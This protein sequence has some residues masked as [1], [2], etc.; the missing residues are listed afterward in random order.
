MAPTTRPENH[1]E[2]HPL[3][4][5]WPFSRQQITLRLVTAEPPAGKDL[6]DLV[7]PFASLDDRGGF[8]R[9]LLAEIA[10]PDGASITRLV[11]KLQSDEYPIVPEAES[12]LWN[13]GTVES[14]W[15]REVGLLERA[16][17]SRSGI[18]GPVE[19]L[20]R[21]P[22][23]AA[24]LPPTIFCKRRRAFFAAPCPACGGPLA[25]FRE[26][27]ALED[28]GL[29]RHDL[30]LVRFL[31]CPACIARG[32]KTLYTLIRESPMAGRDV[33]D[34]GD[35]FRAYRRLATAAP[36][37]NGACLPCQGCA[38]VPTCYPEDERVRGDAPRLL[39]PVTFYESRCIALEPLH[40]RYDEF[41]TLLAGAGFDQVAS[42]VSEP[43]RA[44]LMR[45]IRPYFS[46]RA[47]YLFAQDAGG[48][49]GLEVLRL[50]LTL[51]A[52]LCRAVVNLHRH[53]GAPH[54]A[55]GPARA[56]VL[57]PDQR[58]GLPNLWNFRAMLLGLGNAMPRQLR[59]G[60]PAD[61]PARPY[62][63]PRLIDPVFS[64]PPLRELPLTDQ[65]GVLSLRQLTAAR[66]G[67]TAVLADLACETSEL[68]EL[69]DK[70]AIEVSVVQARPPLSFS[71]IASP[72]GSEGRALRL[73][74]VPA[75]LDLETRGQL[76]QLVNQPLARAR[77]SIYPCLD[78]PCDV[79][80]LGMMLLVSLLG[81]G[82]RSPAQVAKA[83]ADVASQVA[84]HAR[85]HP[86]AGVEEIGEHACAL[87]G[88]GGPDG[89][90]AK[91]QLFHEPER[92]ARAADAI[93]D[94][95][96]LDTLLVGLRAVTTI[97]GF[98]ICRSYSDFDPAHR[99]VN[100]EFLL[101]LVDSLVREVDAS[102][103]GLPGRRREI[104]DAIARVTREAHVTPR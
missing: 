44:L 36:G 10:G 60:D 13:N 69:G 84:V 54:L 38:D 48:K 74:G 82:T 49:L 77:F 19:V 99:E 103:F 93:P 64:A 67:R 28:R 85:E 87:F 30:S 8:S 22:G 86:S 14:A 63:G 65:P 17:G 89:P 15:R 3:D 31:G 91:R 35:L 95:L 94:G 27:R 2:G 88:A 73:R 61:L 21:T 62:V 71:F 81:N 66:D 79:H 59:A 100:A 96:W 102:L 83:V 37:S 4:P 26:S 101:G 29:P 24:H 11:L 1:P 42:A 6:D 104:H 57:V 43:G 20:G 55:I 52:Q 39:S 33:G 78:V 9:T 45:D 97:P 76:E 16:G 53:S 80:G 92:H 51:F 32:E 40:F 56:M 18:P 72:A 50:E 5:A 46:D 23:D 68:R 70:D 7:D 34:Q 75:T 12:L 90:F 41:A 58:S 47:Q 25:D 98:S